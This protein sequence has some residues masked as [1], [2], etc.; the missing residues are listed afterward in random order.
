MNKIESLEFHLRLLKEDRKMMDREIV[1]NRQAQAE[2][3]NEIRRLKDER[4]RASE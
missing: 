2:L 4:R 1:K 3:R